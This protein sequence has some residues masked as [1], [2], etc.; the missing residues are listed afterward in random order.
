LPNPSCLRLINRG[1]ARNMF[2][3]VKFVA[4]AVTVLLVIRQ[5]RKPAW[6]LGRLFARSMNRSHVGLTTW[7]LSRIPIQKDFTILDVGC[8]G[9]QTI[10]TLATLA[11]AGKVYG[12]DYSSAS[13]AVARKTNARLIEQSRVDI[14]IGS[15]SK[16]PFDANMF[17]VITAIETHYY[18]PD[19]ATDLKEILRV[20][21]LG[22]SL[23]IV[24]EAYRGRRMDWLYRP[25]MRLLQ[26]TSY[27][28][29]AEHQQV[30]VDAGYSPVEVVEELSKGWICAIGRK[31]S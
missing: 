7:G 9:G 17:D 11:V 3:L 2:Q 28:T 31:R 15:V 5:C 16:L 14:R 24:A 8:G 21:K 12:V 30:L 22:G 23:V 1:Y 10:A 27:L 13:I 26:A 18:W 4:V 6:F 20:L 25:A 19:L 29:I